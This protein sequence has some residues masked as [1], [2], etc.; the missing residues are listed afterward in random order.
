MYTWPL[1]LPFLMSIYHNVN[2]LLLNNRNYWHCYVTTRTYLQ[3]RVVPWGVL[4]W[5]DMLFTP[6]R[7][8]MCR[9]PMALQST[10]NAEVQKMLHQGVIQPSFSPWLS[11]VV[12]VKKKDGSWSFCIDYHKLNGAT[13]RDAYPLPRV[14][15]TL[16]SLAGSTLFTTLD[17]AS[18]Y[19]K[20]EVEP[21]DKERQHFQY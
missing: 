6:I 17:L 4:R 15:A 10:I 8:P 12:M 9:Q 2:C 16:D 18:G 7:Q 1:H 3:L 20:V 5:C 14:D 19:W 13:H 21:Q 11:L